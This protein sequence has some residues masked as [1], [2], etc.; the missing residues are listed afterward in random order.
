M[1]RSDTKACRDGCHWFMYRGNDP[2][3][4]NAEAS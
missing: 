3:E 2:V 1:V 4:R